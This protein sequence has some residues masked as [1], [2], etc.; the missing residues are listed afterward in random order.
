MKHAELVSPL[1]HELCQMACVNSH[2]HLPPESVRLADIPDAIAFFRHTYPASDLRSAGMSEAQMQHVFASGLPLQ[3]RWQT[4]SRYLPYVRFTGFVQ[5]I[6]IAFKDLF[7]IEDLNADTVDQLS[8]A[9]RQESV[10][11]YYRTILKDRCKVVKSVSQ[12]DELI[13]V[14]RELFT[15]MPR[16]N[17]F[18][19]IERRSQ[20]EDIAA[21]VD[22]PV[23]SLPAL[24]AVIEDV[25]TTWREKDIAGV[26]LSQSYV[27]RM[28][29][30]ERSASDA[31][32]VFDAILAGEEISLR[33]EK[34]RILGDFLVFECCRI[35]SAMGFT[36]QF[37]VGLRAGSRHSMEGCSAAPMV[38]LFR[39]CPEARFDLSHSGFPYLHETTV[40]AKAWPNVYLNMDWI[41]AVSPEAS[42]RALAEWL[43]AVPYN[44]IIAYGDDVEHVEVAY[45]ALVI[46]RQNVAA[47]LADMIADTNLTEGQ[48]LDIA[49][50]VFLDTPAA[51]YGVG[52]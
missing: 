6:L 36:I 50:T 35:A 45:G 7:G 40:L 22:K 48:A 1:Y 34:G 4:L 37:H 15:P 42:R 46:A 44:K 47:V 17:R 2:S 8:Q 30:E 51:L 29:F 20:I 23:E 10:P 25:C 31:A 26:K 33:S 49:R 41:Q 18:S 11:G 24:V 32:Q 14:D 52:A 3:Q 9:V 39:A 28:D 16:L 12:M 19:M 38:N 21:K 5:S 27:R 43:R 13:E